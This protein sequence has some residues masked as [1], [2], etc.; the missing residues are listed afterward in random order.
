MRVTVFLGTPLFTFGGSNSPVPA[1]CVG[2]EGEQLERQ[3]GGITL[4]V[5][6]FLDARGHTLSGVGRVLFIPLGKVDHM[7][8]Q[9]G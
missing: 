3:N 9:E 7:V 1:G 6:R 4:K 5:T 2:L 8:V